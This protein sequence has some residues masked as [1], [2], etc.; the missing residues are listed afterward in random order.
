M[1]LRVFRPLGAFRRNTVSSHTGGQ[2]ESGDWSTSTATPAEH[3][4]QNYDP[5]F[6]VAVFCW[7]SSVGGHVPMAPVA[8]RR[9]NAQAAEQ[10]FAQTE[11][12][13]TA[14]QMAVIKQ[15]PLAHG[16]RIIVVSPIPSL[17][18]V[19]KESVPNSKALHPRWIQW[20]TS[21]TAT[22]VD[23][24]FDPKLQTQEF[25]QYEM[26][27]PVPA[28]TLPFDQYQVVMYTNGSAQPAVG[29]K[30]QY[31]AACAVVSGTME[32]EVF[33]PRHTYTQTLGDCTAQLAE[34]K[35]LLLA[36][37]HADPA[38]LTLLVADLK[39][40]LPK[41][42]VVH[43]LGHQRVGIQVAG[44]TLADEA[45]KSAVAVTTVAAVTRSSS[46]PD[47]EISAAIK[48]TADG[49]PFPKGFPSKY[50]Y[51][52]SGALNAVVNIPG[53]G[54]REMP[55]KIER[56]RLIS[57]AH[58]G[59][60][61]A[62]AGVAAT[63]SLLQARYWWPGLYKETKQYVL[64]CD[65]C[66]QIKASSA[67]RPQQ[68]PLLIS[69]KPLRCVYLDYCGPLMP[70]S[71]YKYILVAVDSCSRFVWVWP[72][73][74]ADAR[75]VIKDLR[76]FV[77]T[78]AV[79]AFHSDQGPAF[80]SRAF[81]DTM[82]SL[83]VQLQFS[84]PFH[85]EGNSVVERL[86]R[87]L[88]QSL[89]ARVIGTG[90]SWLAHLYGVQ[91]ALN[92]LPRRSLGGRTSYE[93]LFGTQM[94]V[95]DLDGPGVEAADTPFDIKD[96]VTVLQ[97]LQQFREDNSSASAASSGIKDEPV[98]PT[99]WIPRIGDLVREKVTVKKEFGPSHRAPVPVLGISGTRT[100]ILPPLHRAKGN[101]FVSI[102]NV[103]LQHVADS[104]QQTKRG[105]Q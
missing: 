90:R 65:V 83:G 40:T 7:R 15:R 29:T 93:C 27:Y 95:P 45:A 73:R 61:S 66:Q 43:T 57:A 60:A 88:K 86:N 19:T 5:H 71:A 81:R 1:P 49:T 77:D 64:C 48:A 76:I 67:R 105:T 42:H 80:A 72:Q 52:L 28:G 63:I 23:Y 37:E 8:S 33:C 62:H 25:L 79:A 104:A 20:A 13:L 6:C 70:D 39:E 102:D 32:G 74:S 53:I 55:N 84:S 96:R 44:N 14:V 9:T 50:S 92:N 51:C 82:A 85:P 99:G 100:V 16:Q 22:D 56:P 78:F 101:R 98:T 97:D 54:V 31:S 4:P 94:H 26:E 91:R 10:R 24:I 38:S 21:L 58:E 59:A 69:N 12:I 87:D 2:R 47:T 18:A 68:T 3:R 103:K 34:L 75:T 89:T 35:A 30:Q 46:K 11:K 36:L 17:E 41:V